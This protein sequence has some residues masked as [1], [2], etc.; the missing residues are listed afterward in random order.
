MVSK[1]VPLTA[2]V[3]ITLQAMFS[4]LERPLWHFNDPALLSTH[5]TAPTRLSGSILQEFM[6]FFLCPECPKLWVWYKPHHFF[7][8]L[9]SLCVICSFVSQYLPMSPLS[10]P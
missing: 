1:A 3:S 8:L 10:S 6:L 2:G 5:C 4:V 9:L 7:H